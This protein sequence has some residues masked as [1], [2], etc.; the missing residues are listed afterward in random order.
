M[1]LYDKL[2]LMNLDVKL[3]MLST[4]LNSYIYIIYCIIDSI[5]VYTF[6]LVLVHYFHIG[7]RLQSRAQMIR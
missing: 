7:N 2:L 3:N 1:F 4:L 6:V 5:L